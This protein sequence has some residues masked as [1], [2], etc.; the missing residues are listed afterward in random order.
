M[1]FGYAEGKCNSTDLEHVIKI[2]LE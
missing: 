2:V 1:S